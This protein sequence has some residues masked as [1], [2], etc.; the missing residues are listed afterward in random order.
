[1]PTAAG[2]GTCSA[3][4]A[5]FRFTP[6]AANAT[7]GTFCRQLG[8]SHRPDQQEYRIELSRRQLAMQ[9]MQR[10]PLNTFDRMG[11]HDLII[12]T[13]RHFPST[14]MPQRPARLSETQR[15]SFRENQTGR[16]TFRILP[17]CRPSAKR[18]SALAVFTAM[19]GRKCILHR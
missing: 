6:C 3:I 9:P 19:S 5:V 15:Q 4:P 13:R 16:H 10:M 8:Q 17:V 1:M 7:P 18:I 14:A 2:A 12:L 11:D